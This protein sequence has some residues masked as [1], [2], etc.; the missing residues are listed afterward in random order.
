MRALLMELRP[1]ALASAELH[2]LVGN[3]TQAALA[4]S[5]VAFTYAVHGEAGVP[6]PPDV[7]ITIYRIVQEVLNNVMKHSGA[8][9]CWIDLWYRA[10][11]VEVAI[12]DNGRGFDPQTVSSEQLGLAIMRERAQAI[13]GELTIES[14]LDEG[15]HTSLRWPSAKESGAS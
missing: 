3:L 6:L 2:H 9:M 1:A 7:K 12:S 13:G 4:R 5:R 15:V 14:Q 10:D 8:S 11:G